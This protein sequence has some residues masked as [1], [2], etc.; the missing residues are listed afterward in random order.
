MS[1]RLL[2]TKFS[3]VV[4]GNVK[5][6]YNRGFATTAL[7]SIDSKDR[8]VQSNNQPV[9]EFYAGKS[10]F[11]TGG[12]GF[13]G[14]VVIEKLLDSCS[15]LDKI[16]VLV[17]DKK[18]QKVNERIKSVF[19]NPLFSKIKESNPKLLD[20]IIPV[21]G[22]LTYPNFGLKP[23]DEKSL[24][25]NVSVVFHSGATIR[26]DEPLPVAMRI[27]F[28]GT[29]TMLNLCQRMKN[30]EAFVYVS[31]AFAHTDKRMLMETVYP[32]PKTLEEI[33]K[34][35]EYHGGDKRET[36]K[37]IS[38]KPNTYTFTK[39]LSESY[40]GKNHGKVPAVIVRPSV[41]TPVKDGHAK[42]WLDNW[43]GMTP[44]LFNAGKGWNRVV[45][46]DANTYVDFIPADYVANLSLIAAARAK[47][48][49]QIQVFNSVST[50]ENPM[51]WRETYK[52]F[53]DE[54]VKIGKSKYYK[55]FRN[56]QVICTKTPKLSF[57][58]YVGS[59]PAITLS[60]FG[61]VTSTTLLTLQ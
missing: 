20:K 37:F 19:E 46:A 24:V 50:A 40:I 17:R 48:S 23:E 32:P 58:T 56:I 54:T 7:S 36:E 5:F 42:G 49:R 1:G 3:V 31:T 10:V 18:G 26:F 22:D 45:R 51:I 38:P 41:V 8:N 57:V 13:L 61:V 2:L 21:T 29:R 15:K 34:F 27:N 9:S 52:Y 55:V 11:I 28:E 16:Y 47:N 12:T 59:D 14:K 39:A 43:F 6:G 30:I 35:I 33:Y 44:I 53:L 25:D 60:E 4:L